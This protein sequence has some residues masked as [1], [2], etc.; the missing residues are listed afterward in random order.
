MTEK[1][2]ITKD[3]YIPV[4]TKNCGVGNLGNKWKRKFVAVGEQNSL[5]WVCFEILLMTTESD[6]WFK[7]F[8]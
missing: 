7:W 5:N 2:K 1:C 8:G 3:V 6:Q 4:R